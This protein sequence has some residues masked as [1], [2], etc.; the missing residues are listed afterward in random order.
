MI[1][2]RIRLLGKVFL[3]DDFRDSY[4]LPVASITAYGKGKIAA[5][6]LKRGGELCA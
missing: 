3:N 2:E 4:L 6:F 5:V 1:P